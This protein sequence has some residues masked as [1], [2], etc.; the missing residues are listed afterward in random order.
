MKIS[1]LI[2]P[3]FLMIGGGRCGSTWI[4]RCLLE[5]PQVFVPEERKE[6]HF[7]NRD[8]NFYQGLTWYGSFFKDATKNQIVGDITPSYLCA[9][10]AA[11]RIHNILPNAKLIV[12][13]RDPSERAFSSYLGYLLKGYISSNT[14]IFEADKILNFDHQSGILEHGMYAKH[15]ERFFQ[16]YN[17]ESCLILFFDELKKDPFRYL[18]RI[19]EFLVLNKE[20]RPKVL[21]EIVNRG[22]YAKKLRPLFMLARNLPRPIDHI[23]IA[24]L[25]RIRD[26]FAKPNPKLDKELRSRLIEFYKPHIQRLESLLNVDLSAWRSFEVEKVSPY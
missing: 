12:S 5:H 4:Y 23:M 14:S 15:L 22:H 10:K 18:Q 17:R 3:D 1:N 9:P 24:I 19:Y 26:R 6:L 13:L 8:S 21:Y 11:R 25:F 2:L 20:F 7:F 16:Y